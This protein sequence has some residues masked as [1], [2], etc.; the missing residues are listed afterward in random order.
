[1]FGSVAVNKLPQR[2]PL[3]RLSTCRKFYLRRTCRKA[4]GTKLAVAGL[5]LQMNKQVE[6]ALIE[7]A[8][9]QKRPDSKH[10]PI[11]YTHMLCPYAQ[12]SLLTLFHQVIPLPPR[13]FAREG[14]QNHLVSR[15]VKHFSNASTGVA[16]A[17]LISSCSN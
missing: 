17:C 3:T 5:P 15:T 16:A 7:G 1:M 14:H 2:D 10:N 13:L 11:L 9:L 4:R 12:R 6:I 8:E